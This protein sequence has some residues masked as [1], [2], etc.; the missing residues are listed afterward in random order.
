M[1]INYIINIIYVNVLYRW[2]VL[3][4]PEG[5][6]VTQI[7][8]LDT[9]SSH[10]L[11]IT[12]T[13][14]INHEPPPDSEMQRIYYN[15]PTKRSSSQCQNNDFLSSM[16]HPNIITTS[17]ATHTQLVVASTNVGTVYVWR[18]HPYEFIG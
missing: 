10:I 1:I 14:L 11:S 3:W 8:T 2:E 16:E 18:V 9:L 17:R 12:S 6:V 5:I 7:A 4:N 13:V 15:S